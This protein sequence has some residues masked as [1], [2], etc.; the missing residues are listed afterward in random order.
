MRVWR[1]PGPDSSLLPV[2]YV[3]HG[4]PGA[5]TDPFQHGL[6]EI[7]DDRLRTGYP[8]FVVAS[9]DG[10]GE[11]YNDTEWADSADGSDEVESRFLDAV[12]PAVEGSHLRD[13]AHRAVAG[14][15][16]GG[17]GAMNI[18]LQHPALF[19]QVVSVAGYFHPDDTSGVFH[20]NASLLAANDP[21]QHAQNA[22]GMH[23]LLCEDAS[24]GFPLIQGQAA[25]FSKL[26]AADHI[27]ATLRITPGQHDWDYAIGALA[28]S[29]D[30][31]TD[32]WR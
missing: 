8:P 17:Y 30:F 19:G 23:I 13:R 10:N 18:A 22:R 27:P 3:L 29:L 15:S 28:G 32:G 25:S 16:M 24:D 21:D 2:L 1:P 6:A 5:A 20:G 9:P 14:F 26:L 12:I 31:L 7:L 11:H 4:V